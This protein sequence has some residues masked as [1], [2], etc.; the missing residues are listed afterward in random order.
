MDL[1]DERSAGDRGDIW[2]ADEQAAEPHTHRG[3]VVVSGSDQVE[4]R[5][6]DTGD[7]D[8]EQDRSTI[9]VGRSNRPRSAIG[10]SVQATSDALA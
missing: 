10:E 1:V 6:K 8:D 3:A 7:D 9:R 2:L 5:G 4:D